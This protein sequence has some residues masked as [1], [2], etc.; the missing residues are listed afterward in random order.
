MWRRFALSCLLL[1]TLRPAIG[2]D[3]NPNAPADAQRLMRELP[4]TWECVSFPDLP[5]QVSHIKHVTPTHYTW[6]TYDRDQREILAISGGTWSLKDGK[7]VEVCEFAPDSH[8][9]LRGKTN[10]FTIELAG[11]K[12]D[13]KGVPGNEIEV[14][15]VWM[16]IKQA[17]HQKKNTGE[18]GRQLLGSWER[19]LGPDAPKVARMVKHVTPTHWTW[20][21]YDR[22]NRMVQA[23]AGGTWSLRDGEYVEA[24]E[25]TTENFPQ[26][27]GNT[28]PFEYRLDG[29]RWILKGGPDRAIRDDETWTRLKRPNP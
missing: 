6:V 3:D 15:E 9:Y 12:W 27:R 5:R 8:Q 25:F 14:D 13:H 19:P 16:R 21:A 24:V 11:E 1:V 18:P 7:Y 17:D 10:V 29:D 26:A 28:S 23:A 2:G 4:G 20:V 22:E